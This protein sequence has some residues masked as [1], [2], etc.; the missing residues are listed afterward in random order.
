MNSFLEKLN[1][2]SEEIIADK[3][4]LLLFALFSR[5]DQVDRWD[6]VISAK[7]IESGKTREI[8]KNLLEK[9]K[10]KDINYSEHIENIAVMSETDNFLHHIAAAFQNKKG[11]VEKNKETGVSI[12]KLFDD[13]IIHARIVHEEFDDFE[14]KTLKATRASQKVL[15]TVF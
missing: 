10:D 8:V 2:I 12:I 1:N 6:L 13:Y 4:S 11:C 9:F 14:M 3:G 15:E 7:W 5:N